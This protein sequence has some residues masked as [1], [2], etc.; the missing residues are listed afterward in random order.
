MSF[1]LKMAASTSPH[2][3]NELEMARISHLIRKRSVKEGECLVWV[4]CKSNHKPQYGIIK[5]KLQ[6][7]NRIK[8]LKVHRM[9]WLIENGPE[10]MDDRHAVSHICHN[11][12]CVNVNHLS[13]E[14][15]QINN[16]R[17]TCKNYGFCNGHEGKPDC[18]I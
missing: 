10:N 12:L 8:D 3:M 2:V 17:M 11:S 18:I 4:G 5:M 6:Y 1:R 7:C 15:H 16:N 14:R 13:L 9:A